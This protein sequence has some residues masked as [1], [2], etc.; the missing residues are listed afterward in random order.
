MTLLHD[1]TSVDPTA[2]IAIGLTTVGLFCSIVL[3]HQI[4][5]ASKTYSH[6]LTQVWFGS[7]NSNLVGV[8]IGS[9]AI[10]LVDLRRLGTKGYQL[11]SLALQ[12]LPQGSI[13]EGEVRSESEVVNA[14]RCS[15]QAARVRKNRIAISLP[16]SSVIIKRVSLP[17]RDEQ[18]LARGI[19]WEAECSIPFDIADVHL[20]YQVLREDPKGKGVET[21]LVAAKRD[22]IAERIRLASLADR[23]PVVLDVDCFALLNTYEYNYQPG[24]TD[25]VALLDVG[26]SVTHLILLR[27][28]EPLFTRNIAVG[29][30]YYSD[31]LRKQLGLSYEA[32][33]Q[34]KLGLDGLEEPIQGQTAAILQSVSD[35]L[36][37]EIE[38]T[39]DY[40]KASSEGVTPQRMLLSGGGS[41][42]R[43]LRHSLQQ[44]LRLPV[45]FLEPFK[46]IRVDPRSYPSQH[47]SRYASQSAVA[48]GLA[49][50][51]ARER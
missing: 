13:V 17:A 21:I 50:R 42:S 30:N 23:I 51:S 25:I 1:A 32:A 38:R 45:Q 4:L 16:G 5:P 9:S 44:R 48:L 6:W 14:I 37:L 10:K 18:E 28:G 35:L 27:G 26:C 47:L 8:D 12:P 33:E 40:F 34:S 3:P 24:P 7:S 36:V 29:G 43:G 49:L 2:Q 46:K 19:R 11:S 15:F 31:F 20:D 22:K 39:L 41:R